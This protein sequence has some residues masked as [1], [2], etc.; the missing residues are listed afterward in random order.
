[1][2]INKILPRTDI[3]KDLNA[4]APKV[5]GEAATAVAGDHGTPSDRVVLSKDYWELAQKGKTSDDVRWDR[6][7]HI[8]S[9]LSDGTY[10]IPV[11]AIAGKMLDDTTKHA[12]LILNCR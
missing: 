6:V 1:M 9:Q 2:N 12:Y 3:A 7:D 10:E 4:S 5:N 11:E 8:R